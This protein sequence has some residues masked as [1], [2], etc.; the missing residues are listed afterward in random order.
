MK[1][2]RSSKNEDHH[3]QDKFLQ[4]CYDSIQKEGFEIHHL[5]GSAGDNGATVD[6]LL[7]FH[8]HTGCFPNYPLAVV[9]LPVGS[10]KWRAFYISPYRNRETNMVAVFQ[11]S[12]PQIGGAFKWNI[13]HSNCF[14]GFF[15]QMSKVCS[16]TS[17]ILLSMIT[18]K[19]ICVSP[20]AIS[21]QEMYNRKAAD[22]VQKYNCNEM[23]HPL[24]RP[25]PRILDFLNKQ[26][27]YS[28]VAYTVGNHQDVTKT[29]ATKELIECKACLRW[30][31]Q[32]ISGWPAM[33]ATWRGG[34]GPGIFTV[35]QLTVSV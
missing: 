22:E 7:Y 33:L 35:I 28:F 21:V 31:T 30:S 18:Q 17:R 16:T 6:Q 14:P 8:Q 9:H 34:A 13:S 1:S 23:N 4:S 26:V 29:A 10:G 19:G 32:S 11:Y 12:T 2:Q 24:D 20:R 5:G 3:I 27:V 25:K 15:D